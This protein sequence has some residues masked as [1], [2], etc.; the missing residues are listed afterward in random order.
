MYQTIAIFQKNP[1]FLEREPIS[2]NST[3]LYQKTL[4]RD[5]ML[6]LSKNHPV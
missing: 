5:L 4:T 6:S 1:G 2:L 3:S